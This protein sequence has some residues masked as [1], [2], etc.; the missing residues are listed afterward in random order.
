MAVRD[1]QSARNLDPDGEVGPATL[2]ELN[3]TDAHRERPPLLPAPEKKY[4]PAPPWYVEAQKWIGWKEK[5]NNQGIETFIKGAKTGALGDP[6]C[7]IWINYDLETV[8]VPGSRSPAARSFEKNP[9]FVKLM[10]PALGAITTMWRGSP[11][12]GLGHVFLYDGE[13]SK[14][15]RGIGANEN[16]EV[17]RSF[18]DRQRITGYWW[19]QGVPLPTQ[20]AIA[21]SDDATGTVTS[22]T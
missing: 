12:S 13:N 5:G 8:G 15:V 19:P 2:K 10:A 18:H 6:Y 3:A 20:Q 7:A 16:D 14:G 4:G 9:H 11:T 1:F 22:E 17:K 21:V